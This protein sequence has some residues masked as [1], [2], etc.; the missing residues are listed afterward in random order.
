MISTESYARYT[1][2]LH[3]VALENI[4]DLALMGRPLLAKRTL[5]ARYSVGV[6]AA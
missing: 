5:W 3:P 2:E 6:G 4:K 1:A